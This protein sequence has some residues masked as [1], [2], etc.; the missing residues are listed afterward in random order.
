MHGSPNDRATKARVP[1]EYGD[2][3]IDSLQRTMNIPRAGRFENQ[4]PAYSESRFHDAWHSSGRL[5]HYFEV[6]DIGRTSILFV[7]LR[8]IRLLPKKTLSIRP[9]DIVYSGF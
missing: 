8:T 2:A 7:L 3:A 9:Y 6:R 1:L 5:K 4:R